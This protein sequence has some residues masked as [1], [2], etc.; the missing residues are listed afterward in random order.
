[1]TFLFPARAIY[2]ASPAGDAAGDWQALIV[3][4]VP[5]AVPEDLNAPPLLFLPPGRPFPVSMGADLVSKPALLQAPPAPFLPVDPELRTWRVEVVA[6][7]LKTGPPLL[8]SA[9]QAGEQMTDIHSGPAEGL[10]ALGRKR[11]EAPREATPVSF[12]PRLPRPESKGARTPLVVLDLAGKD[13]SVERWGASIGQLDVVNRFRHLG[14]GPGGALRLYV[15]ETSDG[16][17]LLPLPKP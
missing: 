8:V 7:V 13:G 10:L 3:P 12:G 11:R 2:W 4:T 1:M 6:T 5:V 9:R 16:P 14:A 17:F 15:R